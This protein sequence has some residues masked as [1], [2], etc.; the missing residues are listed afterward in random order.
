L[1]NFGRWFA[2]NGVAGAM[3]IGYR[4][5]TMTAHSHTMASSRKRRADCLQAVRQKLVPV[6]GRELPDLARFENRIRGSKVSTD[7]GLPALSTTGIS[8]LTGEFPRAC[9]SGSLWSIVSI[10]RRSKFVGLSLKSTQFS[11]RARP[12]FRSDSPYQKPAASPPSITN[13]LP[14]SGFMSNPPTGPN[15]VRCPSPEGDIL[16]RGAAGEAPI[17]TAVVALMAGTSPQ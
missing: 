13:S 15:F 5:P 12:S 16:A 1:R 14:V 7:K 4:R 3:Y 11:N 6:T 8:R 9:C 17:W 10:F 2:A